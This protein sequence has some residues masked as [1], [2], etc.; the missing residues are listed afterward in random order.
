MKTFMYEFKLYPAGDFNFIF[1]LIEKGSTAIIYLLRTVSRSGSPLQ[2]EVL[3]A[4]ETTS[5]LHPKTT[6]HLIAE[7]CDL[8]SGLSIMCRSPL[9]RTRPSRRP[10]L[11]RPY[12]NQRAAPCEGLCLEATAGCGG[13]CVTLRQLAKTELGLEGV[14]SAHLVHSR[15]KLG[16]MY[17]EWF[18]GSSTWNP[19]A[20]RPCRISTPLNENENPPAEYCEYLQFF[21]PAGL[22]ADWTVLISPRT[23]NTLFPDFRNHEFRRFTSFLSR[24]SP[25]FNILPKLQHWTESKRTKIIGMELWEIIWRWNLWQSHSP[26][27]SLH[28]LARCHPL[29]L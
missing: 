15:K 24:I 1:F 13:G 12:T 14:C 18:R 10:G 4:G 22:W 2:M 25:F 11:W 3:G 26:I 17:L 27:V 23:F 19:V 16:C 8:P 6:T 5:H 21:T 7:F 20:A 9:S 29:E 28:K